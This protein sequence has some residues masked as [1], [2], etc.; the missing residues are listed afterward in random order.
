MH[1]ISSSVAYEVIMVMPVASTPR[2]FSIQQQFIK[3]TNSIIYPSLI[4]VPGRLVKVHRLLYLK[5]ILSGR[6]LL[7]FHENVCFGYS[8]ELPQEGHS[9]EYPLHTFL[10]QNK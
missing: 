3:S 2:S 8:L 6:Y 4:P 5:V 9:N 10:W 1:L 7:V